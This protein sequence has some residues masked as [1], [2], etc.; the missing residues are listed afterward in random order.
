MADIS[1]IV[2]PEDPNGLYRK[3]IV[4]TGRS[5][6][7]NAAERAVV[8]VVAIEPTRA[9]DYPTNP[10][11]FDICGEFVPSDPEFSKH[12]MRKHPKPQFLYHATVGEAIR[13]ADKMLGEVNLWRSDRKYKQDL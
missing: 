1:D 5:G 11:S 6:V 9:R 12:L 7:P 3:E 2:R 10:Q 4:V 13:A 8:W